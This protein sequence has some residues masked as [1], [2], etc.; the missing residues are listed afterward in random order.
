MPE[1]LSSLDSSFLRVETATAHMHV[2]WSAL[3]DAPED[4]SRI[5]LEALRASVSGRLERTPRFR[6]RLAHVPGGM[7]EPYWVD[8]EQFDIARHVV[9]LCDPD[10]RP[11]ERRFRALADRALSE[12][13]ERTR[14]LWRVY[15]APKMADGGTGMVAKFHHALVDGRSAVE[16]ALLLFDV[17]PDATPAPAPDWVP[18]PEPGRTRLA[19]GALSGGAA[20]SLRAARGVARIA[21]TP[22]AGG[23]RMYDT[24]RR[25]ALA[26][27]DD[28]LRPAPASYL[29][30][31]IGPK[32]TLVGHR[33][34]FDHVGE[35]R[36]ATGTTVNDV[37]LAA[38]AG[39]LRQTALSRGE[40]PRALKA[41]VPVNVRADDERHD[42][43]NRIS[44]AF[45]DLPVGLSSPGARLEAVRRAGADF[46]QSG[47]P[48]GTG[49]VFGAL[50]MLPTPLRTGAAKMVGSKRVYNL[51]VSNIPGPRVPLY[52]LGAR[53]R[54]AYPVVPLAEDHALS[55]GIF[56]Y[57]DHLHFGLYADPEVLPD[58]AAIP[59]ALDAAVQALR[60]MAGRAGAP[61]ALRGRAA[62]QA[63]TRSSPR[64]RARSA[65]SP[66]PA[67]TPPGRWRPRGRWPGPPAPRR[68]AP[69][70]WPSWP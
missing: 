19:I 25:A 69:S 18:E 61:H 13:L 52:V 1:H 28:L 32:R 7:S 53:L 48:E 9:L 40:A 35:I 23:A 38:V 59:A 21:G 26:V 8:D 62:A 24:V 65:R 46:K 64:P 56:G 5:T 63:R 51:T 45:L 12:P 47:K 68:P 20:E 31:P 11:D 70:P 60:R 49:T 54:E 16:V 36:A 29:N 15:L 39:A 30:V 44:M 42:L 41:M 27:G 10:D 4:G 43:G 50:G 33:V 2:A 66:G 57:C 55:V 17:T 58:V 3:L 6:R 67:P 22:R 14:P 37:C 34:R